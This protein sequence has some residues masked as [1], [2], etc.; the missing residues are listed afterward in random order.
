MD[1][2]KTYG[3]WNGKNIDGSSKVG[4]EDLISAQR[5]SKTAAKY[6]VSNETVT[7]DNLQNDTTK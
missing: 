5:T 3:F 2:Q 4:K 7:T 6:D 1:K